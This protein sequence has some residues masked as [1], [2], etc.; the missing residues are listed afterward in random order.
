M[1][2]ARDRGRVFP[3]IV[4]IWKGESMKTYRYS[5]QGWYRPPIQVK[6]GTSVVGVPDVF[7]VKVTGKGTPRIQ[8]PPRIA[9]PC[10]TGSPSSKKGASRFK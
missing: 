10:S 5:V 4:R 9:R 2:H 6:L 7:E 8:P 1:G 3:Q